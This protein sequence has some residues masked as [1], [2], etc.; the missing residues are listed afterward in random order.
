MAYS[1]LRLS[2]KRL[3]ERFKAKRRRDL[4][5]GG[6]AKSYASTGDGSQ[7]PEAG[8]RRKRSRSF[9]E[10]FSAFWRMLR[11]R[12][13]VVAF[14]IVT[15]SISAAGALAMPAGTKIALDY[16]LTDNP[17][18]AGLPDWAPTRDRLGLLWWL[19]GAI[20]A[21]N[22]VSVGVG[23]VG[24][25]RMT[26][27]AQLT[28][29][30][31]R[32]RVFAHAIR[33]PLPRVYALKTGGAASLLREDTAQAADLLFSLLYNPVRAIVQ[34]IGTL[35]ILASVDWR[36]LVGAVALLP[37]AYW[38]QRTWIARIRPVH[39]EAHQLRM[40]IDGGATE[41]FGGM[42]VVRGFAR[43]RRESARFARANH[44]LSRQEMMAWWWS[45]LIEIAWHVLI[46]LGSVAV[47]IYGG[48]RVIDGSLTIGD[49][50]MFSAYLLMLLGPLE[51]L[52]ASATGIQTQLAAFDRVLD[53]LKEPTESPGE[54]PGFAPQ[55][56]PPGRPIAAEQARPIDP[57][58]VRGEIAFR[59]VGFTYPGQRSPALTDINLGVAAGSTVALVGPSGAGK[60]TLCNLV[61]RFYEPSHG[62]IFLDG[63]DVRGIDLRSYRSLL[64]IVE[65]D[66]FLFDGTI[67]DNI[68]YA[69]RDA[70]DPQ[71]LDAARSANALEFIE[72]LEHG[73]D[74][75]VG[76][77][78]VRL[79][80]GQKQRIAIARALLADPRILILDEATSNL[81]T[82]SEQLIQASLARLMRGRTSFVIAHRLSTIRRADLIV[83]IEAGRVAETGT[84][85]ELMARSGRYAA[86]VLR[87]TAPPEPSVGPSGERPAETGP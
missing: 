81:D 2:S 28:R 46:P 76:E 40:V 43:E 29:T 3:F 74:T 19:A 7:D 85:D 72:R 10:L 55:D 49:V 84:H 64:G 35:A 56:E 65:Q 82:E 58:R 24:R 86:M 79:S 17:G 6:P 62:T 68:A 34:L 44:L 75:L 59:G 33:L 1:S 77:R 87:Q 26:R 47:M 69:R 13:R 51:A 71:I 30:G 4:A 39:R 78:G 66:V 73:L 21:I 31:M 41:V 52:S 70:T 57:R 60:T 23:L 5:A 83:V 22:V 18:P 67:R 32:R 38:S 15:V 12:R 11:G 53:L 42:R 63:A 8:A 45:R 9:A 61:A 48:A 27:L 50:M 80:G 25:W 20:M 16:I 14:G 37:A 54:P 36:L